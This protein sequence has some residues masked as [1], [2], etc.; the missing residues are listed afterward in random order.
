MQ[1]KNN[2]AQIIDYTNTIKQSNDISMAKINKNLKLNQIKLLSLSIFS[3]KQNVKTNFIKYEFQKKFGLR[4]Y[5]TEEA[6]E[7]SDKVSSLRFSTQDI[8]ND[9]FS[10]TNVFRSI[11]YEN[12]TFTF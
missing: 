2:N 7:D 11:V 8:E 3:T 10:F 6:Y 12:G 5:K 1:R 4:N 9:K